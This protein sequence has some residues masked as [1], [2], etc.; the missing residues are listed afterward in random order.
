LRVALTLSAGTRVNQLP[1]KDKGNV[2]PFEVYL[3]YIHA[4]RH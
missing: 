1:V 4:F 3:F 2:F